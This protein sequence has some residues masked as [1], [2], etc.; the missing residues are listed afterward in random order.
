MGNRERVIVEIE[1]LRSHRGERDAKVSVYGLVKQLN[2]D[3]KKRW[4][5]SPWKIVIWVLAIA[6]IMNVRSPMLVVL[7]VWGAY[8][9]FF[10]GFFVLAWLMHVVPKRLNAHSVGIYSDCMAC[11][12]NLDGHASVLGDDVWVGPE[13]C[14]ECGE[15]Y[16]A[17]G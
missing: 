6:L 4:D 12:Y 2:T 3:S 14:P 11:G 13:V 10:G 8:A 15:R 1:V 9:V 5:S 7:P 16:P 17:I